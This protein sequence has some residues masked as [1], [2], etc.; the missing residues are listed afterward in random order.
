MRLSEDN[1]IALLTDIPVYLYRYLGIALYVIGN[2][3]NLSSIAIFWKHSWRKNVCSFYFVICLLCSTVFVNSTLIGAVYIAAFNGNVQ[4]YSPVLCKLFYY[5][6]YLFS[7]YLPIILILGS[8]DRL[9]ISSQKVDTRL[10][11]SKRLAYFSVATGFLVWSV[12]SLHV[13]IKVGIQQIYPT[14]FICYYDLSPLYLDFFSYSALAIS[15]TIPL[16]MIVLSVVAFK[17]VRRI[18]A[19]PRQQRKQVR[20]MTKKD[21]QLLRCLYLHNIVYVLC[22][23]LIVVSVVYS[24][25]VKLQPYSPITQATDGFLSNVGSILQYIPYWCSF[26]YLR[27]YVPIFSTRAEARCVQTV[28]ERSNGSGTRRRRDQCRRRRNKRECWRTKCGS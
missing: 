1:Y 21:F 10:Y 24:R 3:G 7:N 26:L 8:I 17:N 25:V 27:W 19:V 5:V 11:S 18:R 4:N 28:W 9:L 13:L 23:I 12:F 22:S 15:V 20:S 14:V 6:S 2:L 16:I